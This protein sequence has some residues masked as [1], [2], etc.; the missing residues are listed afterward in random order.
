MNPLEASGRIQAGTV[1]ECRICWYVYDP[2]LGD[3]V[4]QIPPGTPFS[5]LPDHWR[6]PRC[7]AGRDKFL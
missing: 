1:L 4:E 5:A 6:C 3:E 7:D 2:A